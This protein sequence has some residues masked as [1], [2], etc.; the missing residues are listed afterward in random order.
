MKGELQGTFRKLASGL[1]SSFSLSGSMPR[2]RAAAAKKASSN[3]FS[4]TSDDGWAVEASWLLSTLRD[5]LIEGKAL[6]VMLKSRGI[7]PFA[8]LRD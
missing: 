5:M 6:S 8:H 2:P 1:R 7:T 3:G 4:S